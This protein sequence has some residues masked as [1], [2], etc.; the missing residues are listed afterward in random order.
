MVT[1]EIKYGTAFAATAGYLVN[2]S[3][4]AAT[5][6]TEI[7]IDSGSGGVPAGSVVRF[8]G[9]DGVYLVKTGVTGASGTLTLATG[10]RADVANNAAMSILA[11]TDVTDFLAESW[12][13]G[14]EE[15]QTFEFGDGAT[16][17]D[18]VLLNGTVYV[19][20]ANIPAAGTRTW[21]VYRLGDEYSLVGGD[22]GCRI[23][24]GQGGV[25]PHGDGP[26]YTIVM[27]SCAGNQRGDCVVHTTV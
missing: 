16:G 15:P 24:T 27:Y 26:V 1:E 2:E 7:D 6:A 9:H 22:R 19:T 10:L 5:G 11:T 18:G 3:S 25:R 8:A 13:P 21:I 20:G 12:S 17:Q 4:D 14:D 23:S